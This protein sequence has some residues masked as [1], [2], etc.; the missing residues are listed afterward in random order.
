[1]RDI[2]CGVMIF[3]CIIAVVVGLSFLGFQMHAYF[4]PKYEAVNRDVMLQSRSYQEGTVRELYTIKRQ[5]EAASETEKAT[6]RAAALHE[7]EIFPKD[8]LPPDLAAFMT[9]IGG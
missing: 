3:V 6:L 7:F 2:L 4:A 5:Y 1:M 8:R 9:E